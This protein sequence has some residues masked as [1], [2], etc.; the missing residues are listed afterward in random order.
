MSG[1]GPVIDHLWAGWR[2]AYVTGAET[3]RKVD[4]GPGDTLFERILR[5]GLP[6][7]QTYILWRG[8]HCFALL[9]AYPYTTGHLMVLPNRPAAQLEELSEAEAAEL[10]AGVRLAVAALK[11]VYHP[12]GVN[13]G[14]N[15]GESAGAGVPDHLHAHV[16]PRWSADTNFMSTIANARVLPE[17]LDQTWRRMRDAWPDAPDQAP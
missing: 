7:E 1:D 4:V 15:L 3:P 6:D 16:L 14:L 11:A 5:S 10:W 8:A 12:D 9:N 2:F 13:V 17:P